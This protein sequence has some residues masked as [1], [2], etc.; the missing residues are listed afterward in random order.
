MSVLT[1][2]LT[3]SSGLADMTLGFFSIVSGAV[4]AAGSG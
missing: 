4:A 2:W 1:V 3:A